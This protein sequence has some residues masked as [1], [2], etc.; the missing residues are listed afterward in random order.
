[1]AK[2]SQAKVHLVE[3]RMGVASVSEQVTFRLS[4]ENKKGQG[5]LGRGL[6]QTAA[7]AK[8]P[9]EQEFNTV[10][11]ERLTGWPEPGRETCQ[12]SQ[13]PSPSDW[14]IDHVL[15]VPQAHTKVVYEDFCVLRLD[16]PL[17]KRVNVGGMRDGGWGG[18]VDGNSMQAI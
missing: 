2:A 3:R 12:A 13:R 17:G 7:G 4:Q 11:Q 5:R 8:A 15:E 10:V 18:G 14:N 16:F 9:R 1:M 6:F